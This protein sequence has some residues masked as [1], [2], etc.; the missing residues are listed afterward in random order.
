MTFGQGPRAQASLKCKPIKLPRL[1]S[2]LVSQ[3]PRRTQQKQVNAMGDTVG[4]QL[5]TLLLKSS[6]GR[7]MVSP[8]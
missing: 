5:R 8:F 3:S 4:I 2:P 6:S 1:R 7:V